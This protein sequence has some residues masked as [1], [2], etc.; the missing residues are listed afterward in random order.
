VANDSLRKSNRGL[1]LA[2]RVRLLSLDE[3]R[4]KPEGR[5]GL[6]AYPSIDLDTAG[7]K[8]MDLADDRG[9]GL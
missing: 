6:T 5:S 7:V 9:K 1:F 3:S 8:A 4:P 2:G